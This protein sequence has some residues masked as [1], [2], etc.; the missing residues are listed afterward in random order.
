MKTMQI[1]VYFLLLVAALTH[2][3]GTVNATSRQSECTKLKE[4]CACACK[5]SRCSCEI[6]DYI[7][8]GGGTSGL[9]LGYLLNKDG[10]DVVV[11]EAGDN[12]DSDP[13][14][15]LAKPIGALEA[16]FRNEFFY[17]EDAKPNPFDAVDTGHY[18]GGRILGGTSSVN[19]ELYWRGTVDNYAQWGGLFADA[20]YV[21]NVFVKAET[22]NGTTQNPSLRGKTG[23]FKLNQTTLV[24]LGQKLSDALHYVLL[25]TPVPGGTPVDVPVVQ[26]WNV[27]NGPAISPQW[28]TWIN[29]ATAIRQSTSIALIENTGSTL[30][31][32][33]ESTVL[34]LLFDGKKAIGVQYLNEGKITYIFARK[35][36]I[37]CAGA[38]SCAVLMKSG[39]GPQALLSQ[40]NI[41]VVFDNPEVGQNFRNHI[42]VPIVVHCPPADNAGVTGAAG[43]KLDKNT[44][45]VGAIPD[46]TGTDLTQRNLE[47]VTVSGIPGTVQVRIILLTPES[48][49]SVVINSHDPLHPLVIVTNYLSEPIDIHRLTVGVEIFKQ[50]IDRL[51]NDGY[52]LVSD[53]SNPEAYVR[54]NTNHIHHYTGTCGFGKVVN[55][56]MSVVGIENLMVADASIE[57]PTIQGHTCASAVLIGAAAYTELTGNKNVQF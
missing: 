36:I 25:N 1:K 32:R 26:D 55:E 35:K 48:K 49:G 24:P 29:P 28:Q 43:T 23:P 22:Y 2:Q 57:I 8:I 46:T 13:N 3:L 16:N 15:T 50:V 52:S 44:A 42:Q 47:F 5:K 20:N 7:I 39:V 53:I 34:K 12:K 30:D 40:Y 31:I 45:F 9:T 21:N 54:A 10:K 27:T 4:A 51:A 37:L 11:L 19:D 18:S 33:T 56:H 38:R 41:P 6:R 14:I 17:L